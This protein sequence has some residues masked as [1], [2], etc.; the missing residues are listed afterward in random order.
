MMTLYLGSILFHLVIK[1]SLRHIDL[2]LQPTIMLCDQP[3]Q[4][5]YHT[6]HVFLKKRSGWNA[7]GFSKV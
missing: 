1:F 7:V 5:I 2:M 4:A 3:Y 6:D